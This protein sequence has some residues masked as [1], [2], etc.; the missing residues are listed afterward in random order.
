[1][2]LNTRDAHINNFGTRTLKDFESTWAALFRAQKIS[3]TRLC[4]FNRS[5]KATLRDETLN[6]LCVVKELEKV[7]LAEYDGV[8]SIIAEETPLPDGEW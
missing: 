4:I 3:L 1:M 5:D 7:Y 2:I 6:A 8:M